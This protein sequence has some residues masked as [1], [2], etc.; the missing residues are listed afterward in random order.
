MSLRPEDLANLM[1]L[2]TPS[3][4]P[5]DQSQIVFSKST[6][7]MEH[8]T[9]R[10]E[11]VFFN[12]TTRESQ[13]VFVEADRKFA[14]HSPK[15]SED[16]TRIAFLRSIQGKDELWLYDVLAGVQARITPGIKVRDFV[17]SPEGDQIAFIS[18]VQDTKEAYSVNRL[19][20]K[21]DGEGMTPGFTHIF[22]VDLLTK[23]IKQI[24]N[25]ESDHGCP[26]YFPNGNRFAYVMDYPEKNDVE[27]H[28]KLA[29]L[30][31]NTGNT[32]IWDPQ[33]RSISSLLVMGDGVLYGV[34]KRFSENSVEF[35]KIFRLPE[36]QPA[37]WLSWD[38][39][40]PV[41]FF[42]LSDV[43]RTGINPVARVLREQNCIVFTGTKNGRQSILIYHLHSLKVTEIPIEC[44][45]ISFDL[46]RCDETECNLIC[47]GDSFD[48][49]AEILQ[50]NWD[51]DTN[52]QV[53]QLTNF[54]H[55]T[56]SHWPKMEVH[57]YQ[58]T[59][60]DGKEIHG[61][62]MRCAEK[63]L[64]EMRGTILVIH[65]G[66]HLAFGNSFSFDFW[67]LCSKG[68]QIVFCNPRGS[69][70]Y[71]QCFSSSI[72]GEWGKSD[73]DDVL[74]FLDCIDKKDTLARPLFLSGGSYGGYLVNWIISHDSRFRAAISERSICNLYS[75]IGNS[76]LGFSI[77][78]TELN[79]A[80]LWTNEPFILERSP[81]RYANEVD[82]PVLL[83]HGE[84]DHRCPIEQS[85]QWFTALRRLGKQVK[86]IRFPGASHTLASSG[87]PKHRLARLRA[88]LE[89]IELHS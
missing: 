55:D 23:Q 26:A 32:T 58:H 37:E 64:N 1:M 53:Q 12:I 13:F 19:R 85:E 88:I 63:P 41:G 65:G 28:P 6:L 74:G 69:Y 54:N 38:I 78:R 36:N 9:Y 7:D 72:L 70:G 2:G 16:G 52:I 47:L 10:S 39:D 51:Y 66:P 35:D 4:H 42:I 62:L 71:G 81:I 18:R 86:F 89:W 75:K 20:Y 31:R 50:V 60:E 29:I 67:Y 48:K 11:L 30:D 77:N 3:I 40:V 21:L 15:W 44:N 56:V 43:K 22:T 76:D 5:K 8:D 46:G 82:T 80:D 17:W 14:D 83:I 57:S 87:R 33:V 49:P 24:T 68:Y 79:G 27:K 61:W 59:S 34:G 45:V 73:A 84:E 25:M